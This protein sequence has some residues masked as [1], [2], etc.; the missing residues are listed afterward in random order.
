MVSARA[1]GP[2][3]ACEVVRA[4]FAAAFSS[5]IELDSYLRALGVQTRALGAG[6]CWRAARAWAGYRH[7]GGQ[8][9]PILPDF[10]IAAHAMTRAERLLTRGRGFYRA[11]RGL[12]IRHRAGR[13]P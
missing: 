2:L 11:I 10:L 13:S 9:V 8:T 12:V 6:A 3:E 7:R 5:E 1:E 4:E